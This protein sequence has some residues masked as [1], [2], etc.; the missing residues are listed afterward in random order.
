[1]LFRDTSTLVPEEHR[2]S[3]NRHATVEKFHSKSVTESVRMAL[4]YLCEFEKLRQPL[5]PTPNDGL[6]LAHAIPEEM[7]IGDFSEG[8]G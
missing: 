1:M 4:C 5:T 3:L 7:L 8:P 2:Y 6:Q